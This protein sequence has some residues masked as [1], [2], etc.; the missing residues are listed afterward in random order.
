MGRFEIPT[1]SPT[2]VSEESDIQTNHRFFHGP[3]IRRQAYNKAEQK[4][5]EDKGNKV[6]KRQ[7]QKGDNVIDKT[8]TKD[9][10]TINMDKDIGADTNQRQES[11]NYSTIIFKRRKTDEEQETED[12]KTSGSSKDYDGGQ[13]KLIDSGGK[14][15]T[16]EDQE[17]EDHKTSGSS[18]DYDKVQTKDSK[19][20]H[21]LQ[22][23][24]KNKRDYDDSMKAQDKAKNNNC[25]KQKKDQAE[26]LVQLR[27]KQFEER[28]MGSASRCTTRSEPGGCGPGEST[29]THCDDPT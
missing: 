7:K 10:I 5:K 27:M 9:K 2:N 12:H 28:T 24:R 6:S 16:D 19:E 13:Q 21:F 3:E 29:A 8:S 4:R 15:N 25:K 18:K 22:E 17:I 14:L 26:S 11:Q 23:L 20:G 1:N